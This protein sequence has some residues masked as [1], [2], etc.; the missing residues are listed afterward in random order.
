MYGSVLL[1]SVFD[2]ILLLV[3][4]VFSTKVFDLGYMGLDV[5]CCIPQDSVKSFVLCDDS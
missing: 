5:L 2:M 3:C 1:S 4:I